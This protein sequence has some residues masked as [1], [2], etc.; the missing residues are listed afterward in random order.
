MGFLHRDDLH[1][2]EHFVR[3]G[4]ARR[5]GL[6]SKD[7]CQAALRRIRERVGH[8]D[9][10]L[11]EWTSANTADLYLPI[12]EG[13]GAPDPVLE[14]VFDE[15]GVRASIAELFGADDVWDR[16]RNYYLFVKAYNPAASAT[17]SPKGHI[18]FSMP[19]APPLYRGF[20]FQV[21]LADNE[22]F[23][24]NLTVH[25]APRRTHR[26]PEG[27]DRG[28]RARRHAGR[29][30]GGA[31]GVCRR[32]GRRTVRPSPDPA[33]RKPVARGQSV[34]ED[35][36]VL[37]GVL[38]RLDAVDRSKHAGPRPVAPQ[39]RSQRAV[40]SRSV[41]RASHR[42]TAPQ[43]HPGF[44]RDRRATSESD[45]S[46]LD[47][48]ADGHFQTRPRMRVSESEVQFRLSRNPAGIRAAKTCGGAKYGSAL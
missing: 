4:F 23:S 13:G 32:G 33:L 44:T 47:V 41:G 37:R 14:R 5:R 35:R 20:A 15:T 27:P 2:T 34:A 40:S 42:R 6:V 24:G 28:A 38:P 22:P 21:A 48:S 30:A 11:N 12:Y 36:A 17:V 25:P 43:I 1:W 9:L 18:D 7:Y 8:V 3:Y 29:P 19:P 39:S 10:P 46:Q 26:H 45:F 16:Q 31:L